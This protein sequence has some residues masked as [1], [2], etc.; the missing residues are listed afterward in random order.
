[1][2]VGGKNKV[3]MTEL[4]ALVES[5]G[6][7]DVVT[8]IQ[9]GNIV[10]TARRAIT[11]S[12]LERAITDHFGID[13]TVVLRTPSELDKVVA[14]NPF[15]RAD[16]AK[17][18]VGFMANEPASAALAKLD[19]ARFAPDEVAVRGRELY[20]FLPNGMGRTKLPPYVDRQLK[21]PTPVRNWNTLT[22][23]VALASRPP[24]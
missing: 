21:T 7:S 10:F 3:P 23:L 14:G 18:H 9:S 12:S 4:R 20:Y 1:V 16:I 6:H 17:V 5:L 15:A 13:V 11:A 24:A 19:T 2:N 22:K 8:F